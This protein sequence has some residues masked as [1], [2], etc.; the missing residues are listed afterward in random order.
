[1][2]D[3]S[4][5]SLIQKLKAYKK[6]YYQNKLIK[7]L[8]LAPA[9]LVS[10][11]LFL[12]SAEYTLRFNSTV[13]TAIFFTSL[14]VGS[15][16]LY[17][18]VI[19]PFYR[20][21]TNN[22]Q[23]SNEEAARQ[24]GRYFP[25][26][27]D[28]LLNTLQLLKQG[29]PEN[30]LLKASIEQKTKEI[31]H[32]SFKDAIP[33]KANLKYFKYLLPP[34]SL[35]FILLFLIPQLF[36][37]STSRILQYNKEFIPEAPFQFVLE[38]EHLNGFSNEDFTL[39]V[40]VKGTALPDQVYLHTATRQIKMLPT[41]KNLFE[42]TFPKVRN[43][44]SFIFEAAGHQSKTYKL[45]IFNRPVLK[46]LTVQLNYP[47]YLQKKNEVLTNTGQ[48]E[49]PEGTKIIWELLTR[50]TDSLFFSFP[51]SE[52]HYFLT[53]K[54][55]Q[56]FSFQRAARQSEDYTISLSNPHS[57]NKD[58]I[59]YHIEVIPDQYPE[60]TLQQFQD[61]T[62]YSFVILGGNI[63]DDY[64]ITNL[65][66]NFKKKNDQKYQSKK[67]SILKDQNTQQ[68]YYQ[69]RL[70]SLGL[71][72]GNEIN[73]FLSVTDNDQVNGHKTSKTAIYSLKIPT[74]RELKESLGK[75]TA[76]TENQTNQTI[77]Q[78]KEVREQLQEA[79]QKLRSKKDLSWQ[80]QQELEELIKKREELNQAIEKLKDQSRDE[81]L[82][83][84]RFGEQ[85]EQLA[86]KA[87]QLQQLMEELLDDETKQLYE[88]L[89]KLLEEKNQLEKIQDQ[90][91]KID[92]KEKNLE[93]ELERTLELFKRM[94]VEN[95]LNLISE[96]LKKAAEEQDQLAEEKR[97]TKSEKQ[98][99]LQ[100]Q[101]EL[102]QKFDELTKDIRKL[103]EMNQ[104]LKNPEPIQSTQEE[105]Q[106]IKEEQKNAQKALE[107]GKRKNSQKAQKN[108]A[109]K[110]QKMAKK[111]EE[112]QNAMEMSMS[113]ENLDDLR[114]ILENLVKLSFN[115]EKLMKDFREVRQSDPRFMKLSEKQLEIKDDAVIIE[116]SLMALA[117]RVFQIQSFVTREIGEMNK[118]I[119]ESMTA[120]KERKKAKAT[121]KQQFAMTSMNNLALLLDD[122]LDQ[123]Q[124]QM[125]DAMGKGEGKPQ[126]GNSPALSEL[127]KQLNQQIGELKKSGISGRE[128]SEEL[129]RLAAEQEKLRQSLREMEEKMAGGE[130]GGG[131]DLDEL[132][133]KMEKTE[134]DLVNK[135]LS[136]ETIKR[137]KDILTRL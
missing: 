106:E 13:R 78:A 34:A 58:L 130:N 122:V 44:T 39:K 1:M 26:I 114:Y 108:A 68:Y 31:G 55:K 77:Q 42:Y 64:G 92:F 93:K 96:D 30:S 37:E 4:P 136:S 118:N 112:M 32:I 127:Q 19:L 76:A 79:I 109:Q 81:Q 86:Q 72:E 27:K 88:E 46:D 50:D 36:T 66:L 45:K 61:T 133:K 90:L 111:M 57:K 53:P 20:L 59:S 135:Q 56:Q 21:L 63:S 2:T 121:A 91:S 82:K 117:N 119:E 115:Q 6:K 49:I 17:Y 18:W 69:W 100:K 67:L 70:D 25:D 75:S 123:M 98:K 65:H 22:R 54:G 99:A 11:Y 60:I 62:L 23:L 129:A 103:Q 110:M 97:N 12:N 125:A 134:K 7:G 120:L 40:K 14:A 8:I 28:K 102:N 95:K 43:T 101:E 47:A 126:E 52:E 74:R 124:Q 89:R 51:A 3:R 128:L 87:K 41:N 9:V 29:S 71:E 35:T 73:Y 107:E 113:M 105:E 116:D 33:I 10:I 84:E 104:E 94:K 38:N 16:V 131:T 83:R 5:E 48:L 132:M 15:G 85:N 24:I 80:N 137:Q